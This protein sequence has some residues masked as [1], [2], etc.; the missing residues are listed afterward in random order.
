M[1]TMAE[2]LKKQGHNLHPVDF[3]AHVR[4]SIKALQEL[5]DTLKVDIGKQMG[6]ADSLGGNEYIAF[7]KLAERKGSIDEKAVAKKL[8]VENLDSYR[9][10]SSTYITLRVESRAEPELGL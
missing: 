2:E 9:K 7:Q 1:T 8:G 3:L 5:E 6:K 4:Q 10:P